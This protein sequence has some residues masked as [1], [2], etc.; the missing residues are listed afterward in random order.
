MKDI[1]GQPELKY[2]DKETFW[3]PVMNREDGK[4]VKNGQIRV[5]VDIYPKKVAVA[6]KVG[7]AREEPNANPFLPPPVGRLQFSLNPWKMFNQLV[8]P[9]L[10]RKI[11]MYC[12]LAACCALCIML[13]PLIIGNLI[14]LAFAKLVGLQ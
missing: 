2:K 11:Y 7:A 12:C 10:R 6:N 4:M 3:L 5:R 14:S 1:P 8:G 9:A 13:A